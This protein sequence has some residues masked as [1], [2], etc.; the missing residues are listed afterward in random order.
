MKVSQCTDDVFSSVNVDAMTAFLT[1]QAAS[2]V[3]ETGFH[4]TQ[5]GKA[6]IEIRLEAL[7]QKL[8]NYRGQSNTESCNYL[9]VYQQGIRRS[10][11]FAKEVDTFSRNRIDMDDAVACSS[12][13]NYYSLKIV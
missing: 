6:N 7:I 8:Q 9:R 2:R 4:E 10:K 13:V 1:Q 12:F 11:F 5:K 3:W